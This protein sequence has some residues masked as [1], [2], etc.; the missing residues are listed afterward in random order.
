MFN[1]LFLLHNFLSMPKK[2]HSLVGVSRFKRLRVLDAKRIIK[3]M[4]KGG[5]KNLVVPRNVRELIKD[6]RNW[7]FI[8]NEKGVNI[9]TVSIDPKT[10]LI[11]G[12]SLLPK[13]RSARNAFSS[14]RETENILRGLGHKKAIARVE[15]SSQR[16][17]QALEYLGYKKS[18]QTTRKRFGKTF[19]LIELEKELV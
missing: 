9:G 14:L 7:Y 4:E 3:L 10:A 15:I 19:K 18:R 12:F 6:D 11:G 8:R 13:Y 1:L 16:V 2:F 17:I 5:S